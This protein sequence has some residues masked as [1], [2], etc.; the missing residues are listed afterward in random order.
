M[1]FY[2]EWQDALMDFIRQHG[3]EYE[4]GELYALIMEFEQHL[5]KNARGAYFMRTDESVTK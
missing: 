1:K 3:K 2:S 5:Q 4:E